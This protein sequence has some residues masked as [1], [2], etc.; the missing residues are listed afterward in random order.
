VESGQI[1]FQVPFEVAPGN[2]VLLVQS[3]SGTSAEYSLSVAAAAPGIFQYNNRALATNGLGPLNTA[4]APASVGSVLVV[5]LTGIGGVTATPPDGAATP[6]IP[7]AKAE[8]SASASIG[9]VSA[10]LKFLGLTPGFAGLAQANVQVPPL[11]TGD[12]PLVITVNGVASEP[13]TVSV[14]ASPP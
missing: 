6:A 10:P 9:G 2:A 8:L 3:P 1:N 14:R 11:S 12:Y 5:Y 7:L 13:A 4:D